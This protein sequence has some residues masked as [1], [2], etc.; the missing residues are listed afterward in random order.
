MEQPQQQYWRVRVPS[1]VKQGQTIA[2]V[3]PDG[4]QLSVRAEQNLEAGAVVDVPYV[5]AAS[6]PPQVT[7]TVLVPSAPPP[8]SSTEARPAADEPAPIVHAVPPVEEA[9][10]AQPLTRPRLINGVLERPSRPDENSGT[11]PLLPHGDEA[12][13]SDRRASCFSWILYVSGCC[14]F[15]LL[16]PMS[17]VCWIVS[18]CSYF[19]RSRQRRL[20]FPMLKRPAIVSLVSLS[21]LAIALTVGTMGHGQASPHLRHWWQKLHNRPS[22]LRARERDY[23]YDNDND[24]DYDYDSDEDYDYS[25]DYDEEYDYDSTRGSDDLDADSGDYSVSESSK[26]DEDVIWYSA[27][28]RAVEH[29]DITKT[30]SNKADV[31]KSGQDSKMP[32]DDKTDY[33]YYDDEAGAESNVQYQS[34]DLADNNEH[35][36]ARE[37]GYDEERY[38]DDD[39][40]YAGGHGKVP[41][42]PSSK[43]DDESGYDNDY[44]YDYDHQESGAGQPHHEK[45]AAYSFARESNMM[46]NHENDDDSDALS[47]AVVV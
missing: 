11:V 29:N 9:S 42:E 39:V 26:T 23:D 10:T 19:C 16:G 13:E 31:E 37:Q 44:S 15:G 3:S 43:S 41:R 20:R 18:F 24:Y 40:H 4:Q 21:L 46:D 35:R 25:Y 8:S 5:P 45:I 1:P 6:A 7:G 2:F 14:C 30:E 34:A 12:H 33:D 32:C 22:F 17:A 27:D 36:S 38:Y 47:A 28:E